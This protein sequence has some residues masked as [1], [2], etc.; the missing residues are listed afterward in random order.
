MDRIAEILDAAFAPS[1]NDRRVV[2]RSKAARFGINADK[3]QG[4]PHLVDKFIDIEPFA[5]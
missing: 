4:Y 5:R 3:T 2:V 1:K